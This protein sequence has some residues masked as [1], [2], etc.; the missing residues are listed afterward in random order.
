MGT[1]QMDTFNLNESS[2]GMV[3]IDLPVPQKTPEKNIQKQQ[4]QPQMDS[5][6]ISDIMPSDPVEQEDMMYAQAASPPQMKQQ[7]QQMQMQQMQSRQKQNPLNM[8]DDQFQALVAGICAIIAFCKP[9]QEKLV[10]VFPQFLAD[11]NLT[12]VGLLVSGLIAAILYYLGQRFVIN[13]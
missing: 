11:G 6:P 2:D 4:Q 12:T 13:R 8:S 10:G 1:Y 3:P 7:M 5:T 9:V